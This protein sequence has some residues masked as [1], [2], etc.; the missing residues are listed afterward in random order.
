MERPEIVQTIEKY[1]I[2]KNCTKKLYSKDIDKIQTYIKNLEN[3]VRQHKTIVE[4]EQETLHDRYVM[5]AL[6]G[7]D[8]SDWESGKIEI[9]KQAREIAD[10]AMKQRK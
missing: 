7:S 9:V 8:W 2:L 4:A 5:S 3:T 6:N 10:E 1:S